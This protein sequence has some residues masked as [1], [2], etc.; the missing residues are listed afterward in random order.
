MEFAQL[1]RTA[2]FPGLRFHTD[3]FPPENRLETLRDIVSC[4]FLHL[5]ITPLLN[6]PLRVE[7]SL[8]VLPGL[9]MLSAYTL[10]LRLERTPECLSDGSDSVC[11]CIVSAGRAVISHAG[12]EIVLAHGDAT[13]LSAAEVSTIVFPGTTRSIVVSLPVSAL[14]PRVPDIGK[15]LMQ[16]I[17]RETEAL[18]LLAAYLGFMQHEMAL[19]CDDLRQ[20]TASHVYD[21]VA[22]AVRSENDTLDYGTGRGVH[23]ARLHAIKGDIIDNLGRADLSIELIA[24]RHGMTSRHLRR[25]FASEKTT[26]SDFVLRQRLAR[27][28]RLI[29]SSNRL[30]V[31]ISAVAFECGFGDLSYFNRSFRRAYGVSPRAIRDRGERD[32]RKVGPTQL[33]PERDASL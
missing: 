26:F 21:V 15:R 31:A 6:W 4:K 13:L 16:R 5:E 9:R 17:H 22:L 23:V 27:A 8:R 32:E 1:L 11:F 20:Q 18:K 33:R 25:L 2:D 3:D 29:T 28:H 12:R 30:N 10:G 24:A 7:C 14:A 19:A